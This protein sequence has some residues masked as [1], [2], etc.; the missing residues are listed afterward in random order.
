MSPD[1]I[2]FAVVFVAAVALF[3]WSCFSRFRLVAVGKP[4]DRFSNPGRRIWNMLFFA[5]GQRRVVSR[6]FGFNHFVFFW[7]FL[8]LMVAN[9][10]FLL[11]GLFPDYISFPVVH[12]RGR[13]GGCPGSGMHCRCAASGVPSLL[14]RGA[15]P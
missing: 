5:F 4:E 1:L 7:C 3:A 12:I 14:H 13:L 8:I 15:Q 10:E 11:H 2:V 9:T 6:P